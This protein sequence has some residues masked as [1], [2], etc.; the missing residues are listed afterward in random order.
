MKARTIIC[1]L[2]LTFTATGVSALQRVPVAVSP[3]GESRVVAVGQSCPTFSWTGVEWAEAYRV[4]VFAA[5]STEMLAYE[6]M[7]AVAS[8]VLIK[9]IQGRALSWTPSS[10]ERLSDGGVYVWYVQAEDGYGTGMWSEGKVF[11]VEVEVRLVGMQEAVKETLREHGV[12]EE[13]ITE[14]IKDM[15]PEVQGGIIVGDDKI[16]IQGLEGD[17]NTYYGLNAGDSTTGSYNTFIGRSA[18]L[19]NTTGNQNTFLGHWAGLTNS[20]GNFNTFIGQFAGYYN[21]TAGSNTFVGKSAGADNTTGSHNTFLGREAGKSNI[22]GFSNTYLGSGAGYSNT[23][24]YYNTFLG[25]AAG[26]YNTTG[27]NNLFIGLSTGAD[28]TTGSTNTF[29]GSSA[30]NSNTEGNSNCFIGYCAG[31]NNTTGNYNTLI[32]QH[33]GFSNTEGEHN[34][35]MGYYSGYY[36]TTGDENTFIGNYAGYSNTIGY[37]NTYIGRAAGRNNISGYSNTFLGRY[38][39]YTNTAGVQNVFLGFQAGYNETGS[40]KLYIDNSDTSS[41]LIWGDFEND[42]LAVNGQLCIGTTSSSYAMELET[43][44]ENA[45]FVAQRTDGATNYINATGS[46]GNFG[47]VTNHPLRLAVNSLWRMRLDSDDSLTMK[48]GATCTAG[49]VWTDASSVEL[50]ENIHSLTTEEAMDALKGLNP[51]KYNYKTDKEEDCVGFIAEEVPD[52]VA[53]KD[54]K[55]MSPMDVVAVLTKVVQEQQER[56]KEQQKLIDELRKEID[57]LKKD[58]HTEK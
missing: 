27:H 13:V 15:E 24:G 8:P 37:D 14:V 28:N 40:N 17:T 2:I 49:G 44:G 6:E 11:K 26:Y 18:G 57:E 43:T 41:P 51:V 20:T 56:D 25:Q 10:E 9:E 21:T 55:G 1:F 7:Q 34:V 42:I 19:N 52:L 3:G 58:N 39:G 35:F 54:R 29:L 53:S 31:Y 50:K 30:G 46:F 12:S 38:A 47:T 4:A 48:N 5:I 45:A 32:S 16:S 23:T 33:A 22:S 36:N